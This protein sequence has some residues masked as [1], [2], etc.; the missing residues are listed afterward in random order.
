MYLR[1]T[2]QP[3]KVQGL[4]SVLNLPA[5]LVVES[6]IPKYSSSVPTEASRVLKPVSRGSITG[7]AIYTLASDLVPLCL[8]IREIVGEMRYRYKVVW[9]DRKRHV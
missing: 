1:T 5:Q 4:D 9:E 7:T 2:H 6:Q 3:Y 8:H